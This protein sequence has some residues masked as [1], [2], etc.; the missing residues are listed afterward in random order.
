MADTRA[1]LLAAAAASLRSDGIAGL[2]ARVVAGRAGV[3]QALIFYHYKTVPALVDAAVRHSVDE[4]LA[5]YRDALG[6]VTSLTN[7]LEVGRQLHERERAAG[8]VAI[9]AQVMAGAQH[10]PVLAGA[11]RYAMDRWTEQVEAVVRRVLAGNPIADVIEPVGLA[12]A[13]SAGFIGFELYQGVDATGA[14]LALDALERLGVL[15]DAVD[16][17]GAV[18]RRAVRSRLRRARNSVGGS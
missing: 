5:Q 15:V 2:S 12:R 6:G 14:A 10:D 8:N 4:S 3:N 17:L 7:L 11:A 9:M 18:A 13:I 1:K 16:D